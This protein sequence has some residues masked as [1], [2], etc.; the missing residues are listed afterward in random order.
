MIFKKTLKNTTQIKSAKYLNSLNIQ[1]IV[2]DDIT[3]DMLHNKK[4]SSIVTELFIRNRKLNSS[5]VF[6]TQLCFA[7]QKILD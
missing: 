4:L 5:L 2:S 1:I 3:F 6:V 7:Y